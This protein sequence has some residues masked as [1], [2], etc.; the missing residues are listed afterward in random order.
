[1]N[2]AL[3]GKVCLITGGTRGIGRETARGVANMGAT[4]V[5]AG[6]DQGL[7]DHVVRSLVAETGNPAITGLVADLSVQSEVVRLAGAFRTAHHRLDIL[8][9]NAG[10]IFDTRQVNADGVEM[11]WA[12][13]HLAPFRLT[14]ELRDLLVASAPARIVTV[15]SN[16][17]MMARMDFDDLQGTRGYSGWRAYGQSKLANILFTVELA[18][19][20]SGMQVT[21]N[22]AHPGFVAS[23]FGMTGQRTPMMQ[24][25]WQVAR[26]FARSPEAGAQTSVYLAASPEVE[27]VT[28]TYFADRKPAFTSGAARDLAAARRLW[29][30]SLAQCGLDGTTTHAA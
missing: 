10:A 17:H 27:G 23:N 19:R 26:L 15:A 20:L 14:H 12:L 13:N 25:G 11:T 22:A 9:N 1:M 7:T 18:R 3:L 4:V 30:V 21:A 29:V 2:T 5:V 6:R 16:A 24:V 28:G 8:V